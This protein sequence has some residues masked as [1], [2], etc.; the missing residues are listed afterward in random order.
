M[1]CCLSKPTSEDEEFS[2]PDIV[3][4]KQLKR[5][6]NVNRKDD[7]VKKRKKR[8]GLGRKQ[9]ADNEDDV[10]AAPPP[11]IGVSC[12]SS[13]FV[14]GS[15]HVHSLSTQ[16]RDVDRQED[17]QEQE[18]EKRENGN[19]KD[20]LASGNHLQVI[21][22][23]AIE[24]AYE[25]R[26]NEQKEKERVMKE[27]RVES[28]LKNQA[29]LVVSGAISKTC[30]ILQS[31]LKE[32]V[33]IIKENKMDLITKNQSEFI[34]N[35]A[36]KKAY[37]I[38]HHEQ[39]EQERVKNEEK[40]NLILKNRAELIVKDA[41]EKAFKTVQRQRKEF[42]RKLDL[43]W[44]DITSKMRDDVSD[45]LTDKIE[46]EMSQKC[47]EAVISST[48]TFAQQTQATVE[49][50]LC[51]S[52]ELLLPFSSP[53]KESGFNQ[54]K[55]NDFDMSALTYIPYPTEPNL[56]VS[57]EVFVSISSLA[58]DSGF[59][60]IM[61]PDVDMSALTQIPNCVPELPSWNASQFDMSGVTH[62]TGI[63][64]NSPSI[65]SNGGFFIT[66]EGHQF[67]T[68]AMDF[69][70]HEDHYEVVNY[71]L[72]INIPGQDSVLDTTNFSDFLEKV[73]SFAEA[74]GRVIRNN[75]FAGV[76]DWNS[77]LDDIN[78]STPETLSGVYLES[79]FFQNGHA[80]VGFQN[81]IP[82]SQEC[83]FND[84]GD[85]HWFEFLEDKQEFE[86]HDLAMSMPG[87]ESI[88]CE[89]NMMVLFDKLALIDKEVVVRGE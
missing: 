42:A 84:D 54:I 58:T 27:K 14:C 82:A 53:A 79:N 85:I 23:D 81:T 75:E 7:G 69:E 86:E 11:G 26:Q 87:Q 48:D 45:D 39:K 9:K 20:D 74:E 2:S 59:N 49:S 5:N 66:F 3:Q 78:S 68:D 36:I 43:K 21:V 80:L 1:G 52:S 29:E 19:I 17:F 22:M 10:G 44:F 83:G 50:D 6:K 15:E 56:C 13:A 73:L 72:V 41:I 24:R 64:L 28:I 16:S 35:D 55:V 71:D 89:E 47:A 57:S 4:Q 38:W 33:R 37:D 12:P 32:K 8:F 63:L 30:S 60:H 51:A 62:Y 40:M 31:E 46:K 70:Y 67:D 76:S 88:L 65:V 18:R 25:V 61:V 34:V 77:L